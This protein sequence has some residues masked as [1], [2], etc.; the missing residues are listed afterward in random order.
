MIVKFPSTRFQGSK[1]KIIEW[2]WKEI[3]DYE[4]TTVL[5]AF[6]GTGVVS[7]FLRSK[8]KK[9]TYNDYLQ[10]NH[11]IGQAIIENDHVQLSNED[12]D[13]ILTEHNYEY[14]NFIQNTFNDIYYTDDE[15]KLL[16]VMATNIR[17]FEEKYKRALA[18]FC[19]FQACIIKR[20]FNLFHRKNL[21]V[22]LAD[23]ERSFGNKTTWDKSFDLYFRKFA[24]EV[25]EAVFS[26]GH[27][28][29]AFNYDIF[30]FP[31]N[32]FDLVYIDT[33]YISPKG[34]GVDYLDF[35]HFLEGIVNY[36][37][38][39]FLIDTRYK[40]KKIKKR[41][42]P[43]SDKNKIHGAF[44]KLFEKFHD[45]IL[46]VSYRSP[47]IPSESELIGILKKYKQN[48]DIKKRDYKY[49][50]SNNNIKSGEILLIGH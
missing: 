36:N 27:N 9:V 18:Y 44:D 3:Q 17:R 35:Y 20:P 19:L 22:R 40:H 16:D 23:V 37:D 10:F 2:I 30:D 49:V 31:R 45:S 48:V 15:N 38:W 5:D 25:N 28:N 42:N 47:G 26:N 43:W 32:D 50:L 8:Y 39:E 4:F 21:Y 29:R 41:E 34:V 1:K 12:V 33:P 13:F 46:V 7:H 11:I 14:P 6:G 24:N